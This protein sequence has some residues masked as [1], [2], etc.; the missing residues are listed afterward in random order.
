MW[1][2]NEVK[3]QLNAAETY[4][5][6]IA[7]LQDIEYDFEERVASVAYGNDYSMNKAAL[8]VAEWHGFATYASFQGTVER[9]EKAILAKFQGNNQ[10]S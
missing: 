9:A 4:E 8:I 2:R 5:E 6:A 3:E 1:T 7:I 10:W